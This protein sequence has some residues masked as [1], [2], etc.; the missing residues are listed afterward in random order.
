[1]LELAWERI[2]ALAAFLGFAARAC[3]SIPLALFR[4]PAEVLSQ[5]ER[6]AVKSLGIV[7]GAGT[8]VGLVMWLQT[9][10][11]LA[12]QGAQSALPSFLAVAM[13]VEIGPALAGLL[14][15]SRVGAGLAAELAAMVV[16]EEIDARLA[17][18]ADPVRSLVAP[19]AVACALAV[20]L[21]TVV[22]DASALCGALFAE[23]TI[24]HS[25]LAFFWRQSLVFLTLADI[26]PAT[27]KTAVFGLLIGLVA[28]WTG[29][30]ADRSAEAVGKAATAS[31][32]R[33]TLTVFASNAMLVPLIQAI[34]DAFN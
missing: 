12:A 19:R 15:A 21:L 23:M 5:F 31:V 10:R 17:L 22:I 13:L 27:L 32:V 11:L 34:S 18:G 2:Y 8:C 6:V 7:I 4:H 26:V 30:R 25:S 14:V 28:S 33:S 29:L 1:M 3:A 9:H 16:N 24:G 20:P